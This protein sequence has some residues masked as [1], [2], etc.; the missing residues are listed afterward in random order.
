[1]T[2][3]EADYIDATDGGGSDTATNLKETAKT[4]Q[5]EYMAGPVYGLWIGSTLAVLAGS[6]ALWAYLTAPLVEEEES[7]EVTP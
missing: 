5:S 2:A 3:A 7:V 1:M 4:Q 6:Y